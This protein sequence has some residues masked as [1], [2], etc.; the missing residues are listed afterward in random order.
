MNFT[1]VDISTAQLVHGVFVLV[2]ALLF[3]KFSLTPEVKKIVFLVVGLLKVRALLSHYKR[4]K[5]LPKTVTREAGP[6]VSCAQ[7]EGLGPLGLRKNLAG[8]RYGAAKLATSARRPV[9]GRS[10]RAGVRAA[11]VAEGAAPI[12]AQAEGGCDGARDPRLRPKGFAQVGLATSRSGTERW[13][14]LE[15]SEEEAQ[16]FGGPAAKG[17]ACLRC[18]SYQEQALSCRLHSGTWAFSSRT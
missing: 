4:R 12:P 14:C 8:L 13:W 2:F 16:T 15:L 3:Y 7:G 17:E 5:H 9:P 18:L 11:V 6:Q 10:G 1:S